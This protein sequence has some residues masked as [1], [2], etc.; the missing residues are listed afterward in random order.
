V[1]T[2]VAGIAGGSLPVDSAA[3]LRSHEAKEDWSADKIRLTK[4]SATG[5]IDVNRHG[6]RQRNWDSHQAL[7]R[8]S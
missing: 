2:H 8:A 4:F 3:R 1:K 6:W 5:G 7:L